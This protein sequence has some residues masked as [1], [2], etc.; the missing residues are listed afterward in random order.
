M[1]SG[2]RNRK[3]KRIKR[4]RRRARGLMEIEG[5]RVMKID[6]RNNE[7]KRNASCEENSVS[8]AN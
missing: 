8:G 5:N 2:K 7:E 6:R 4:Q 3:S 1:A